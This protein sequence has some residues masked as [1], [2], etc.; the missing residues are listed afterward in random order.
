[1][2]KAKASTRAKKEAVRRERN[3]AVRSAVKTFIHRAE[4]SVE[5]GKEALRTSL[6]TA[7]SAL[8][9]AAQKGIIHNNNAARRLSRLTRRINKAVAASREAATATVAEPRRR[10]ATRTRR[11]T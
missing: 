4:A 2:P 11:K 8:G 5:A 3:R 1:M 10:A 6:I 7:Q 9:K